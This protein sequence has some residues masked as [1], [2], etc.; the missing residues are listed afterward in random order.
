MCVACYSFFFI[1]AITEDKR[2]TVR[3]IPKA[4]ENE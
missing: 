1:F 3:K 4:H 2:E